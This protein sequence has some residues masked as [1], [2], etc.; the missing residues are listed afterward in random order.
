VK[1]TDPALVKK[2]SAALDRR[3]LEITRVRREIEALIVAAPLLA[4]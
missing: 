4:E 1:I 3:L 2:I